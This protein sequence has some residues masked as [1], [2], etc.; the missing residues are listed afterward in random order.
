MTDS[1]RPADDST[2]R[3]TASEEDAG[4]LDEIDPEESPSVLK[5]TSNP[6]AEHRRAALDRAERWERGEE[7]PRVVNF[8][9]PSDLRALLTDRRI[10]MLD[11]VM[12]ER[13]ESIRG[14]ADDLGRDV[15][16]VHDD[17]GVLAEYDIVHFERDGRAKRPFV[18]YE[19]V[20]INLEISTPESTDDTAPA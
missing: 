5:L 3:A 6:E 11:T 10:E 7:V 17:L 15:K 18:P 14:L 12:R 13:P 19:T 4:F 2:D 1:D 9:N 8:E 20:E 16:S